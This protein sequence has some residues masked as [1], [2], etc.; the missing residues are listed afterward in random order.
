MKHNGER[1]E[2]ARRPDEIL[3][4]IDRTRHEMDYTLSAIEERLTP[5]QLVDQG[6]DYLRHS[7][8]NEFV[9]NLGGQ[10]KYNPLP[11]TLVG[12]GIA[13]LMAAG[14]KHPD[15]GSTSYGA[16]VGERVGQAK[17][18]VTE[19]AQA[20]RDRAGAATQS[21]KERISAIGSSARNQV[22]RAKGGADYMMREQPLALG[23]IG[24]AVGALFAALAPRT[25]E[26]DELMGDTRDRLM[27]QA[28]EVGREKLEQAKEAGKEK[29]EQ[30]KQAASETT[31]TAGKPN[32][33]PQRSKHAEATPETVPPKVGAD[34][35][36]RGAG[37]T[38][39]TS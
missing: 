35:T 36:P 10:V 37:G 7:G 16:G 13:W 1:Q 19:G 17:D 6:I 8:A 4:E 30:A 5:G 18:K 9:Q 33:Q 27:D 24:L 28:K 2:G 32:V 31:S 12:I 39:G 34:L 29:L 21:A 15:Y 3:A 38:R 26:E 14:K 22:D 25:R 23:V 20:M 11:V